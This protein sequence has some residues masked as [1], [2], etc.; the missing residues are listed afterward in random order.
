LE[1]IYLQP[2]WPT[3]MVDVIVEVILSDHSK[4]QMFAHNLLKDYIKQLSMR[5]L[6]LKLKMEIIKIISTQKNP[7]V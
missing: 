2:I 4:F 7:K 5:M 6:D 3:M 1:E